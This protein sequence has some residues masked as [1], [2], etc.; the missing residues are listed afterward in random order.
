[1]KQQIAKQCILPFYN[2]FASTDKQFNTPVG[3]L[4][5]HWTFAVIWVIATP[6]TSGGYGFIIGV[7]IY[8]QLLIGCES[9][10]SIFLNIFL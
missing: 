1:V 5:L 10:F 4:I 8:G 7:F 6:N 9:N 2:F 3:A